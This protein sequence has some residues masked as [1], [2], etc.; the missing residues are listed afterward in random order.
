[1]LFTELPLLERFEAAARAGFAAVEMQFPYEAPALRIREHLQA[2]GL[3][4]VLHNLPA[5]DFEAGERGLACHPGREAEFKEGLHRAVDYALELGVP[6]LNCLAGKR[7]QGVQEATLQATLMDNLCVA[8]ETLEDAGLKLLVEPLNAWDAPDFLLD[9]PAKAFDVVEKVNRL[10]GRDLV[11]VQYDLYHAHRSEGQ[12]GATLSKHLPSIGHVQ[13]AD[14]PGRHEPGTGEI[15][16]EFI[17]THLDR[18][19]YAGWIGCE[20]IPRDGTWAGLGW[21]V[22]AAR[23]LA[24]KASTS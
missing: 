4:M 11:K 15:D 23:N 21:E 17:F 14:H 19:G 5:G 6:Q 3:K 20:Y 9:R 10:L 13:V 16:W 22:A 8:A 12:L 1:M 2:C 24:G 7:R 18:L